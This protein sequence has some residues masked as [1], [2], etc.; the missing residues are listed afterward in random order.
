MAPLAFAQT[1]TDCNPTEKTC[2]QDVG[3][4]S[5]TFT[6]DFTKGSSAFTS[7][8]AAEGTTI[9]YGSKGAEFTIAKEGNAPTVSTDF[10]F[11]FGKVEVVMQAATGTGIVSSIVLESDD[12]DE[13]D[14]EFL[15]GDITQVETNY[16][17]KGNTTTYNRAIYY[18]VTAPQSSMHTYTIDWTSTA[19]TFAIDGS[20]VRTLNYADANGGTN[21]PQTPMRL[22]LGSWA[23]GASGEPAGTVEWAG[24]ATDFS[25]APFSMYVESISVTN[26]NP[27][28]AYEYT[29]KTGSFESIKVIKG[30][31]SVASAGT[32][33]TT[34]A[35]STN[36]VARTQ[37]LSLKKAVQTGAVVLTTISANGSASSS[38]SSHHH[39][40]NVTTAVADAGITAA[41]VTT[42]RVHNS[43]RVHSTKSHNST[44]SHSHSSYVHSSKSHNTTESHSHSSY[45]HSSRM[46][47]SYIHSTRS[48]NV[49]VRTSKTKASS[50]LKIKA[51]AV[52][53]NV[54][55]GSVATSTASASSAPA[56]ATKT[57]SGASNVVA[58]TLV[59]LVGM[60]AAFWAL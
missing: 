19:I 49:T 27:G 34:A 51:T 52:G 2:A 59:A 30:D 28:S 10:Y 60:V 43:T 46:H 55:V 1:F 50:T 26:Y 29:D 54:K 36:T 42:S 31:G 15:G 57:N 58:M 7:W 22:K 6:S 33:T 37:F 9:T 16:F 39:K 3:L 5:T 41:A 11:F 4:D 8:S 17:G 24:G 14:W 40:A 13:I 56:A 45:M 25:L 35:T 18:P 21:Y 12:L 53:S 44:E 23:G 20:V 38:V 48:H 47:S 32:T